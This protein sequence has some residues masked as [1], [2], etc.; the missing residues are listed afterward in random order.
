MTAIPTVQQLES[1]SDFLSTGLTQLNLAIT[2]SINRGLSKGKVY[3]IAG[4]TGA[5]KT[6]LGRTI[7]AE[8]AIDPNFDGYELIYDDVERGALMDTMKFFGQRLVDRLV[9]PARSKNKEPLYSRTIGD[10]YR[11]ISAKLD[12]GKKIIW[13]CDSMDA[14][15][16]DAE[17]KMT[18]GKAKTNSQNLRKLID[19]LQS[20]GSILVLVSQAHVNM[21]SMF[22]GD[23]IAGGL[24]LEYYPTLDIRLRKVKVLKTIYKG[25]K[26]P[27]GVIVAAMVK[28]NRMTGK[29]RIVYFPFHETYG[30]DDIGANVDFLIRNKHWPKKER[31]IEAEDI[32]I[33]SATR[34]RIIELVEAEHREQEVREIVGQVW[35]EIEEAITIE[36]K[37]KYD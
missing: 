2:G 32:Q 8:A 16:S 9:P 7:L 35:A 30:I 34:T 19:P 31:L 28:K 6:F 18:D 29:D 1:N 37:P 22:G 15:N 3:R 25:N 21:R 5:C 20:S 26:I 11:R 13:I 14:L 23:T 27:T 17:S 10:F 24:A 33:K 12:A 4:Y 36:R